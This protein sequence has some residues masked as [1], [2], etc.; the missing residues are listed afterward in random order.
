MQ[1]VL[2]VAA[3]RG[4]PRLFAIESEYA[5]A[6]LQTEL[7][8]T[9][10]LVADI[11]SDSLSGLDEWRSWYQQGFVPP[12]PTGRP[13]RQLPPTPTTLRRSD[14][15]GLI[16]GAHQM[17]VTTLDRPTTATPPTI[18]PPTALPSPLTTAW[19]VAL[20]TGHL[21]GAV[22]ALVGRDR[23]G[24]RAAGRGPLPPVVGGRTR[25]H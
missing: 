4:L 7:E 23:A 6:M 22:A 18:A 21:G 1:A 5:V 10:S 19:S 15:D 12:T 16:R 3:K 14:I 8:F 20:R 24:V 9:R 11:E 25:Q 2:D 17:T 13:C